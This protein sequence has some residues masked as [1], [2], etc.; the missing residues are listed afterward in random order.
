MNEIQFLFF[1]FLSKSTYTRLFP[2]LAHNMFDYDKI[3]RIF[4]TIYV[5]FLY[6]EFNVM[7]YPESGTKVSP[8]S[9]AYIYC[10]QS[11]PSWKHKYFSC[12]LKLVLLWISGIFTKWISYRKKYHSFETLL[13]LSSRPSCWLAH[14]PVRKT[15][16]RF[17]SGVLKFPNKAISSLLDLP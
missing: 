12:S 15:S 13:S 4:F 6:F 10:E 16:S 14:K 17:I 11:L 8:A 7:T 2:E 5:L 3:P 9:L 1:F